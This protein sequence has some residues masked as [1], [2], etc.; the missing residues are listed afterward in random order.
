VNL[1]ISGAHEVIPILEPAA[2][3]N[4]TS[5]QLRLELTGFCCVPSFNCGFVCS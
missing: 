3:R 1:H 2:D 4:L 5:A